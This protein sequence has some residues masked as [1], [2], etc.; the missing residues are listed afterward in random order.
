VA[1][2]DLIT[3]AELKV[4]LETTSTASDAALAQL[5]TQ[6]SS[7]LADF[8][9][10]EYVGPV[11]AEARLFSVDGWD[12]DYGI[13]VGDLRTAAGITAA[14]LIAADGTST[15]LTPAT[16]LSALPLYRP[17]GSPA[18]RVRFAG[19]TTPASGS[20]LSITA[21][22]GWPEVPEYVKRAAILTVNAWS[23]RSPAAWDAVEA[24]DGR[25][26]YPSSPD[27]WALPMA[28]K[29]LLSRDRRRGIV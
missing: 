28:A 19:G 16:A 17:A 14:A 8:A 20:T 9:G 23:R 27:G 18:E 15:A 24:E 11:A 10:R 29:Q 12:T 25:M 4:A 13:P 5:I 7:A 21:L 2:G 1:A 3:L 26:L 6:A 22:W